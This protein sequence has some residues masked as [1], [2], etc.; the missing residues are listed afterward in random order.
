MKDDL[1]AA[2]DTYVTGLQWAM[3]IGGVIILAALVGI[4]WLTLHASCRIYQAIT[5]TRAA[6]HDVG[7]DALRLLQDLDTHLTQT[8]AHDPHLAA[9]YARLDAAIRK[10]TP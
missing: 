10:E 7:P 3:W 1:H 9:A 8:V 6:R 2:L 5:D 4:A